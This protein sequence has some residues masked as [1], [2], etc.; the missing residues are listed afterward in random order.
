M[1]ELRRL[2]RYVALLV[3]ASVAIE[4]IAS[5]IFATALSVWFN[6][7]IGNDDVL[8]FLTITQGV[9]VEANAVPM[10]LVVYFHPNVSLDLPLLVLSTSYGIATAVV[11]VSIDRLRSK[12]YGSSDRDSGGRDA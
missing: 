5:T 12:L 6:V 1:S 11:F 10:L 3:L 2:I 9:I 4:V 7:S 8:L